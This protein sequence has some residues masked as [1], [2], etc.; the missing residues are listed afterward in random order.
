MKVVVPGSFDPVTNGH[1]DIFSRAAA[2]FGEVVAAVGVNSTKS[3]LFTAEE[4]LALVREALAGLP[5]VS[6]EPL[7][8]LLVDFCRDIGAGAIVK[9]GRG[10]ADFEFEVQMAQMN[11]ALTEVDTVV[12]PASA[13]WA[14]VSSTLVRQIATLGGDVS[15]F[16]PPCVTD[17]LA[18]RRSHG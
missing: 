8:G 10:G 2:L 15:A 5:N 14:Y 12:L 13:E 16:V 18:T 17:K 4:R 1:L 7:D 3:Y 9:G 11:R 6:A